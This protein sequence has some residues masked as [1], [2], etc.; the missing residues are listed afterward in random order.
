VDL[1]EFKA[2]LVYLECSRLA[3]ATRVR[4]YPRTKTTKIFLA[5][6]ILTQ[7]NFSKSI[8]SSP[9]VRWIFSCVHIH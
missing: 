2:R 6:K 5:L 8:L 3:R 7:Y 4:P 9:T 1:C